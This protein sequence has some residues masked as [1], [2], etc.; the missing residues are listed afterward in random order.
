MTSK[1]ME[2]TL[3]I[4]P[5]QTKDFTWNVSGA[6]TKYKTTI[7][8]LFG[9]VQEI[10]IRPLF[11][12]QITPVLRVGEEYGVFRGTTS[13]RDDEGNLLIDPSNGQIINSNEE[14]I[15]GNPNPDFTLGIV[16]TFSWKGFTLGAVLDWKQGGDLYSE[17]VNSMM[18]RGVLAFQAEKREWG[19]VIPGVYG[20]NTTKEAL[21]DENGNKIQNQ[22][23]I[24]LNDLYFGSTFGSN[25][26]D[27]WLV[28]D[29]TVIRLREISL[30]YT[31]PAKGSP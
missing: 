20:S 11:G 9:D 15:I 16:N 27:E 13:A 12:G 2:I 25:A 5:V 19:A 31:I 28:F 10:E 21:L 18:G 6:F 3:G 26:Q 14:A 8:E 22:T 17:T 1:G 29:A 4:T 7:D 30:G 23:M 24:E